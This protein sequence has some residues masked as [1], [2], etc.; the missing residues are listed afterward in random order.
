LPELSVEAFQAIVMLSSVTATTRTFVGVVGGV[1]S[2]L[3]PAKA[4]GA[5]AADTTSTAQTT[6][7]VLMSLPPRALSNSCG[8]R[9]VGTN[10]SGG[11]L[12]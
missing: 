11:P 3:G 1:V 4:V 9:G 6:R 12:N 2:R 8:I 7:Q 5:S 10:G